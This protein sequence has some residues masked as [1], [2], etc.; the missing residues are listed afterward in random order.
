MHARLAS[1]RIQCPAVRQQ[2]SGQIMGDDGKPPLGWIVVNTHPHR[3]PFAIENLARQNF[4]TYCP[5]MRKTLRSRAGPREV[6][7]PLF[8]NYVFVRAP[9]DKSAWRPILSTYGVRQLVRFGEQMPSLDSR[10]I[11]A[12]RAREVDGAVV[13]PAS[14]YQVGEDISISGGPFDGLVARIVQIESNDRLTILMDLLGQSIRGRIHAHQVRKI[15]P[16]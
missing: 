12:L 6:L 16:S 11:D 9:L 7:R 13:K 4:E 15:T 10:F 1:A 2:G 3:E 14:P 5:H 8:A